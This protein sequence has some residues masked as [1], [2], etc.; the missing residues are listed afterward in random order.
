MKEERADEADNPRPNKEHGKD[1]IHINASKKRGQHSDEAD[2]ND[3]P[4]RSK[5]RRITTG[6][7]QKNARQNA[8]GRVKTKSRTVKIRR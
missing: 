6:T 4:E 5:Q 2:K 7:P 3:I 1:L 8:K